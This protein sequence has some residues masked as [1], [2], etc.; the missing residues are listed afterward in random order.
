M[1]DVLT[2]DEYRVRQIELAGEARELAGND[3]TKPELAAQLQK[4]AELL[5]ND[6]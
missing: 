6:D 2:R 5:E 3:L 4:L 1:A